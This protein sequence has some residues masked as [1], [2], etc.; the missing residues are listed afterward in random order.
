MPTRLGRG[1]V[2]K[3]QGAGAKRVHLVPQGC[4]EEQESGVNEDGHMRNQAG[5][6]CLRSQV[7]QKT[8]RATSSGGKPIVPTASDKMTAR[9]EEM[10]SILC[11]CLCLCFVCDL[12]SR[13]GRGLTL[14]VLITLTNLR[15]CPRSLST[16]L[17]CSIR[18]PCCRGQAAS[19]H[20]SETVV[21]CHRR[22]R[23]PADRR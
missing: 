9:Y 13:T 8:A 22:E 19:E 12:G 14:N 18:S 23:A 11:V 2:D 6:Y 1:R 3:N 4:V 15:C 21:V 17:S 7:G 20:L 5:K 16:P 10:S